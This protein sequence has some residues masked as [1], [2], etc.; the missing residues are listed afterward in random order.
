MGMFSP[1]YLIVHCE[2]SP[3]ECSTCTFHCPWG[4]QQTKMESCHNLNLSWGLMSELVNGNGNVPMLNQLSIMPWRHMGEWLYGS[5]IL[6]LSTRWRWVVGSTP[7][8]LYPRG[9]RSR[10]PLARR[11]GGPQSRSE[12]CGGEKNLTP[13]K[14]WTSAVQPV[15]C[16]YTDWAIL[17]PLLTRTQRKEDMFNFYIYIY[18]T[19]LQVF[20]DFQ[21]VYWMNVLLGDSNMTGT[22]CV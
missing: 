10:Y 9:N 4:V 18:K 7:W 16:R 14:I 20:E 17:T 11:L 13:T 22:I 1:S 12:H 3:P 19:V 6:D 21:P 5:T 15:A 2:S 8:S